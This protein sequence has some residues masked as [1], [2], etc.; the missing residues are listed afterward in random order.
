[1]AYSGD[2]NF[3]R[4]SAR[5]ALAFGGARPGFPDK[6]VDKESVKLWAEAMKSNGI[7]HVLSLLGDDE[8][9]DFYDGFDVDE[10][11]NSFF[12]GENYT[13]TSVFVPGAIDVMRAALERARKAQ[14][15]IVIHCSGGAGRAALG[16]G[17]WLVDGYGI[18]P[19]D[20]AKEIEDQAK[21]LEGVKRKVNVAKLEWLLKEGTMIGFGK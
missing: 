13:R 4:V 3:S 19:Q 6:T 15:T 20:A 8:K 17:L 12:G 1:M 5:D 18:A 7:T 10:E 14:E 2:L 16:M 9:A 11:M 21:A